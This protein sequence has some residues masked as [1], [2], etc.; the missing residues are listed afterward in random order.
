MLQAEQRGTGHAVLQAGV[1]PASRDAT[2][3]ILNG[4]LPTLRPATLRAL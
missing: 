1:A 4:D 3:L 2:L